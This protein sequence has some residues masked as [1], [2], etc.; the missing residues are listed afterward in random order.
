[1]SDNISYLTNRNE[2]VNN[3]NGDGV[4]VN[5]KI[6]NS[7]SEY[8]VSRTYKLKRSTLK[9]LYQIKGNEDDFNTKFN[10]IIDEAILYYY[11]TLFTK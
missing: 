3:N 10:D 4:A 1:M 9:K 6:T 2:S 5:T 7:K 11:D 8:V